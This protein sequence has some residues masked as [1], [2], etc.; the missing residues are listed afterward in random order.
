MERLVRDLGICDSLFVKE[1]LWKN[2]DFDL[3]LHFW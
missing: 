2:G 1:S 3:V